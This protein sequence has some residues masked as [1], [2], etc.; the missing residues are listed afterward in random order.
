MAGDGTWFV[1]EVL[2]RQTPG[3]AFATIFDPQAASLCHAAGEGARLQVRA[4]VCALLTSLTYACSRIYSC[5]LE[6]KLLQSV[7]LASPWMHWS[8]S[9]VV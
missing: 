9:N 6:G 1:Q 3:V 4:C 7:T 8:Q 5:D 2:A